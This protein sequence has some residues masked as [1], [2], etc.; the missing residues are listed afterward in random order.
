[1][2]SDI[3]SLTIPL[4]D[5][6]AW[7]DNWRNSDH[8]LSANSFLFNADDFRDILKEPTVRFVR[9]YVGL[10]VS[11]DNSLEPKLICVGADINQQDILSTREAMDTSGVYDF[12]H[13]CPPTCDDP[14]SPLAGG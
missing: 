8:H 12:S 11:G 10:K 9:L 2:L 3:N 1:M 6:I 5:G 13:P 7:T 14:K 4:T